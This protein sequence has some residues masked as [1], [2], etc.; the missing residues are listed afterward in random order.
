VR[1]ARWRDYAGSW[2]YQ[3]R[4]SADCLRYRARHVPEDLE[5][6]PPRRRELEAANLRG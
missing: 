5:R 2:L 1:A 3:L 4:T 6:L